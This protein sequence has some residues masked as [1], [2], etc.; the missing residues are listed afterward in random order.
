MSNW[1]IAHP[2]LLPNL[3]PELLQHPRRSQGLRRELTHALARPSDTGTHGAAFEQL[4]QFKQREMLRTGAR[5]LARL[6]NVGEI[7]LEL[8]DVWRCPPG[9]RV[10]TCAAQL[11]E[12]LGRPYH[13]DADGRWQPTGFCVL[14]LGKLGGQELNY[15]SDVDVIFIYA[16]EG[17]VFKQPPGRGKTAGNNP[18][19]H[20]YFNRLAE[21]FIAEV[22]RMTADG[23]LHRCDLRLRP[24]G[25]RGR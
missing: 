4:R 24:E 20:Q 23:M 11:N 19:S 12:R 9:R 8:S 10:A 17:R 5:D 3:A 14:G 22:S 13:Q 1:L 2:E 16:E 18:A 25:T 21:M 7:I 6:A 15:S